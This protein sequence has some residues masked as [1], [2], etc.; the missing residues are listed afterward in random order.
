MWTLYKSETLNLGTND[1]LGWIMLFHGELFREL[2]DIQQ[3]PKPLPSRC[4]LYI[5]PNYTKP[6][7]SPDTAKHPFCGKEDAQN[8]PG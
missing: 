5:F 3:Y 6:K 8:C 2:Q 7:V 4:Q 1:S